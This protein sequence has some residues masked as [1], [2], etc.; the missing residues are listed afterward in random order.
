M[1][2]KQ[3]HELWNEPGL[4][5]VSKPPVLADNISLDDAVQTI[6][7]WFLENFEDPVHSSPYDGR[8]GGYQYIHGGPYDAR[9]IIEIVF[10]ELVPKEAIQAAINGVEGEATDWTSSSHRH[11]PPEEDE[12]EPELTASDAHDAM[13]QDIKVLEAYLT[14]ID[15]KTPTI[16]HNNP[17]ERIESTPWVPSDR[18]ELDFALANLKTQS[19]KPSSDEIAQAKA[20]ASTIKSKGDKI[21][22]WFTKAAGVI[23]T[24]VVAS[25]ASELGKSIY[26]LVWPKILGAMEALGTSIQIWLSLL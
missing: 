22:A 9:E 7:E 26:E 19:V 17:P 3:P 11:L 2:T 21:R 1:N 5:P 24:G 25:F 16:G 12:P 6:S 20:A 8:E 14:E 4:A 15:I 18:Q 13:L 23:G 10:G